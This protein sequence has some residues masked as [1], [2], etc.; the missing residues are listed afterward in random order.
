M[1]IPALLFLLSTA[2]TLSYEFRLQLIKKGSSLRHHSKEG[3][4]NRPIQRGNPSRP[5]LLPSLPS[6]DYH[7]SVW[8]VRFLKWEELAQAYLWKSGLVV[9]S[10][11]NY[12]IPESFVDTNMDGP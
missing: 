11:H 5:L 10:V 3:G 1:E 2:S 8:L 12:V 7:N 6:A 9:T 4:P